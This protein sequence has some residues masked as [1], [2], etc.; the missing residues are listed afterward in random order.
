MD[1]DELNEYYQQL[2]EFLSSGAT[3]YG[4]E[5]YASSYLE[6]LSNY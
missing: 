3:E 6:S 2:G 1:T 5:Q 4:S